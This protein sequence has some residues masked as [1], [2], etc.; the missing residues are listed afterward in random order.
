MATKAHPP[1]PP[2]PAPDE[3]RPTE[4]PATEEPDDEESGGPVDA[5]TLQRIPDP[6]RPT[7]KPEYRSAM[8]NP[9][10]PLHHLK[11]A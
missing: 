9:R 5:S 4:E 3:E 8:D 7:W 10:H 2:D 1:I 6:D 11:D